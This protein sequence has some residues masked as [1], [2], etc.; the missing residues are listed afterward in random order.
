L[1]QP[2]LPPAPLAGRLDLPVPVIDPE[3]AR[4]RI[5]ETH[6]EI[7]TARNRILQA[8]TNLRLQYLNRAPDL[9][10]N[11]VVQYDN[12][13][14]N[15]QFN[16]QLGIPIPIYDRNQGN[17][18]AAQAQIA[19]TTAALTAT[20]NDL[21][22]RLADAMGRYEANQAVVANYRDKILPAL[23]QAYRGLIRR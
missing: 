5:T 1:G 15:P 11:T 9:S 16:L 8:E 18:R 14:K 19:S 12:A 20:E 21:L 3:A 17:I 10:T 22:S 4:A 6:T 2:D 13:S 7:L 23:A